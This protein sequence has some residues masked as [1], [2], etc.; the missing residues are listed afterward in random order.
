MEDPINLLINTQ[1]DIP[2]PKV[3]YQ[4][5][6]KNRHEY[7]KKKYGT[8]N[9]SSE[10]RQ[11][12][13]RIFRLLGEKNP[14]NIKIKRLDSKFLRT[15]PAALTAF[16]GI[17]LGRNKNW[18]FYWLPNNYLTSSWIYKDNAL[19]IAHE[20]YHSKNKHVQKSHSLNIF[21]TSLWIVLYSQ[22]IHGISK[23]NKFP[24]ALGVVASSIIV[25][26]LLQMTLNR[27][28]EKSACHFS[29]NWAC[30][31]RREKLVKQR[32]ANF[33]NTFKHFPEEKKSWLS[34]KPS[35]YEYFMYESKAYEKWK[36]SNNLSKY[37]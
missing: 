22:C 18:Y 30:N 8:K 1:Y 35:A 6:W 4:K 26:R 9:C 36:S 10:E 3:L 33:S 15:G 27:Y 20:V 32:L 37:T 17:W 25:S 34:L 2:T 21:H 7:E 29:V 14:E 13:H 23:K 12:A 24:L 31:N 11:I 5:S 28:Q 16:T 19:H